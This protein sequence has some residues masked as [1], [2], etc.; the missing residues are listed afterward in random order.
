MPAMYRHRSRRRLLH[1]ALTLAVLAWPFAS[2]CAASAR[3]LADVP[4]S[5]PAVVAA[6]PGDA[7]IKLTLRAS[8][9]TKPVFV[10]SARDG[11]GRL[12]IVEQTGRIKIYKNG[13]VLGTPFLNI[14]GTVS[15]GNEQGLLGL[16]FHPNFKT[17]RKLYVNFTNLN[18]T[19]VV[20]EYRVSTSNPN[21]VDPS[22]KRLILKVSQ[23][24]ENHNGGMLAFGPDGFLYIGMGDGGGTGDPGA[25]AQNT[26]T[27]LGKMLRIDV[28]GTTATHNYRIPASNPFVGVAGAD[29]IWQLGLRN[30]WRWSFD[31]SSHDLW[32][33]DVG[34]GAWEEI[35]HAPQTGSGAGRG[36]NWGWDVLEGTH[37]YPPSVSTC[38]TSGKTMPL[39][40]Y[41]HGGGRCAV[42]GGYVYRGTAIPLLVGGYVFGDYCSGEI[43]VVAANASAP[44][45]KTLL[46]D[47]NLL[48]SSFGENASGEL[49]VT[50]LGGRLYRIDRA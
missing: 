26:G 24:Y 19:T 27:L 20:R 3:A 39:L 36:V 14:A 13:H 41:D 5:A 49:L 44:A 8:G 16:A 47:T 10:T 22:T 32:I 50:D 31:R 25:R 38:N 46:L 11:S 40:E 23:P 37:C 33:G 15:G 2:S 30:P 35:D 7:H 9:L 29:E 4:A 48:I 45:T 6:A 18:G 28:N 34:Q 12:F 17:N 1:V 42:T 43:W 21:V